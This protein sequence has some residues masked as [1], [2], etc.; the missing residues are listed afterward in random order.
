MREGVAMPSDLGSVTRVEALVTRLHE[1]LMNEQFRPLDVL[2]EKSIVETYRV[3]RSTARSAVAELV[4]RGVL[5]QEPNRTAAV[6]AIS[7]D[8]VRD[9][10]RVRIPLELEVVRLLTTKA[11][12]PSAAA[13]DSAH[14]LASMSDANLYDFTKEDLRFHRELVKSCQNWRLVAHW[15]LLE[16]ELQMAMIQAKRELRPDQVSCD[17][18]AILNAT[19]TG[20]WAKTFSV[21]HRHL[22]QA[23]EELAAALEGQLP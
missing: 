23:R 7:S 21:T 16:W 1:A 2:T 11:I 18:V 13:T 3:S 6:P 5:R 14:N 19:K 17:H 8:D 9:M 22:K 15:E 20:D 12:E 4:H 10:F